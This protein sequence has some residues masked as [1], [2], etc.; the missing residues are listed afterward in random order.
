MV[1]AFQPAIAAVSGP[2][3]HFS[4]LYFKNKSH[5]WVVCFWHLLMRTAMEIGE[6]LLDFYEREKNK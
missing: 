3:A 2:L 4:L 1:C 6:H 5:I